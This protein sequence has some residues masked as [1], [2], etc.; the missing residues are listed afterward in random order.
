MRRAWLLSAF[1]RSR[2][3][4]A[5][6][7]AAALAGLHLGQRRAHRHL[8]VDLGDQLRDHAVGRRRHL[9]VDLVGRNLDDGISL[10]YEVALGDMPLEHDALGDRLSHFGHLNLHGRRLRHLSIECMKQR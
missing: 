3:V 6:G 10:V 1:L 5:L 8:V 7:G 9:G 2:A 4:R